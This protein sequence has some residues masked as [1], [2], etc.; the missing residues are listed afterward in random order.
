M[1]RALVIFE[2]MFGNT[3]TIAEA[4]AEVSPRGS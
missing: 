4:V 3:R 1:E 2:S